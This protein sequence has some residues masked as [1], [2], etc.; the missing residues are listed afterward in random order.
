MDSRGGDGGNDTGPPTVVH[1]R[2][3]DAVF[4]LDPDWQFTYV[5]DATAAAF[6]LEDRNVIGRSIWV[7]LP[8]LAGAGFQDR[9]LEA[10]ER[11]QPVRVEQ[12]LTA[13]GERFAMR[14]YP[15][16]D[17]V[18]VCAREIAD[19]RE[20]TPEPQWTVAETVT[21]A[22]VT[23]DADSTIRRANSATMDVFGY[24]PS[25]LVGESIGLLM[26]DE[27]EQRHQAAVDRYLDTGERTMEWRGIEFPGVRK[28][29]ERVDLSVSLAAHTTTGEQRFTGV[30]RDVTERKRRERALRRATEIITDADRDLDEKTEALLDVVREAVGTD[31]A[32]VS[33]IDG[34]EYR[35]DTVIVPSDAG[36]S[37][38]DTVPLEATNCERV[39]ESGETLAVDDL[40][41]E[42]PE[43][44]ERTGNVELGTRCYLGAP[45][46]VDGDVTG[47]FCF[48]DTD[49]R[50][51]PFTDWQ[52]AFVEHL[53]V[54]IGAELERRR[55]VERLA[56]LDEL[57]RVVQTVADVAVS[58][59]TRAEIERRTCEAIAATDSYMFAWI[60]EAD[61][62]SQT[63][64][65]RAEAGV[66]NYSDDVTISVDPD[67]SEAEGPTGWAF[68]TGEVQT[69]HNVAT[70][71]EYGPWQDS[72]DRHGYRS[73]AAIP[74][75]HEGTVYGVLNVYTDRLDAFTGE[76]YDVV[77]L[78]GKIVGH[79][80]AAIDRRQVLLADAVV[81][82]EFR[83][84]DALDELDA[85][86]PSG[87][88]L[89]IDAVVPREGGEYIVF[90]TGDCDG[91]DLVGALVDHHP[92]WVE[93]LDVRESERGA[94]FEALLASP[95]LLSAIGAAGGRFVEATVTD[96]DLHVRMQLPHDVDVHELLDTVREQYGDATLVSKQEVSTTQPKALSDD[97]VA[98]EELTDRRVEVLRTAYHAGYFEWPR[99]TSGEGVAELLD[100]SPPTFSQH[101]RA[102][103]RSVFG[104]LF[105]E[106]AND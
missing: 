44:A 43:L 52:V 94:S 88:E 78:L 57:N 51:D 48:Y 66:E 53:A 35:F 68:R 41:L 40:R 55:Y 103:E 91:I 89:R 8:E 46:T 49:P 99:G 82:L 30:I 33:R 15:G 106:S 7:V 37:Q 18:T 59:P 24:A 6:D 29:G 69:V 20:F 67:D 79:A 74:I 80:I 19:D 90:G 13:A 97:D 45:V 101:L 102:A 95:P 27:Q 81:D 64:E 17:G 2:I 36:V 76:E 11:E 71:P 62:G 38:G 50:N 85:E 5:D 1:G 96:G 47:T 83:V 77:G 60:G 34:D 32:T 105:E 56:A 98:L 92:S 39:V 58:Q 25:E 54:W 65:S 10:I 72:V 70:D 100:I 87:Y 61:P 84:S 42:A 3:T 73:S 9:C 22:V 31:F 104:T 4:A 21:D 63:V 12:S 86:P 28:D 16:D 75:A 93:L 23:I 14:I 26:P